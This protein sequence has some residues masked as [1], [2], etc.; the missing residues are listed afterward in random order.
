MGTNYT[1]RLRDQGRYD[2]AKRRR[3]REAKQLENLQCA[4]IE[5]NEV[6]QA[7]FLAWIGWEV[8]TDASNPPGATQWPQSDRRRERLR[9]EIRSRGGPT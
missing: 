4:W 9:A 7:E 5:A 1:Q 3:E 6:M 8:P 2:P